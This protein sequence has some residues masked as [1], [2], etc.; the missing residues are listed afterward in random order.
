MSEYARKLALTLLLE[1]LGAVDPAHLLR[2]ALKLTDGRIEVS[3]YELSVARGLYVI[4]L[5]KAGGYMAEAVESI[6]GEV[7]RGGLATVPRNAPLPKLKKITPVVAGHPYPDEGSLAAGEL[8]LKLAERCR[9]EGVPLLVLLSGGGSAM[10]EVPAPGLTLEDIRSLTEHLLKCGATIDEIN[11]VRKHVSMIKG[12]R[13]AAAAQPAPVVTLALS[14]VVGD[15]LDVIASG[16]TVPDPTS[17][18]DALNVIERY[19]LSPLIPPTV[20]ELLSRGARGELPETPKPGDLPNSYAV[21]IGNNM[22]ALRAM[23]SRAEEMGLNSVILSSR[24]QG[25][26]REVARAFSAIVLEA[27]YSSTPVEPPA[28][29]LCGGETT[30]TVRG[31]GRGG[32][33]QEFALAAALC[34]AG[35]DG[36]AIAAMGSDGID[37]ETDVAGAVVDG[38]T[39]ERA[40]KMGLDP[41]SYLRNNDSYTFFKL[42]GGHIVTGPT[43]TNVNDFY[44]GVVVT[45]DVTW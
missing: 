42:V 6:L 25:E 26:A 3:G 8:A 12:G 44:I 23:K 45:E 7:I 14:D 1:G 37:G 32:R 22:T 36:V 4:S 9:Q 2:E 31:T 21:V 41:V 5:G 38:W 19:G 16:P 13:L 34:I 20:K 30:V 24:V 35:E 39:V 10:A 17:Y 18:S 27:K 11:T 33:N 40:R 28:V 29:V 43:Y 15:R